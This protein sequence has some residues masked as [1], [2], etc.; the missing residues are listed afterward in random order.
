MKSRI[1]KSIYGLAMASM[2]ALA[3]MLLPTPGL[4]AP[5]PEGAG[6][7][8]SQ[9]YVVGTWRVR[10]TIRDCHT[11]AEIRTFPALVTFGNEGTL[12]ETTAGFPP[13]VRTSGHGF[14]RN[15]GGHNYSA[16]S[17]AFLFSPAGAWIGTQRITQTIEFGDDRDEFTSTATTNFFDPNGNPIPGFPPSSCA[18]AVGRRWNE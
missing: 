8:D 16:V 10:V 14:W 3:V 12:I 15:T 7:S 5:K 2:F 11:G 4:G 18:T 17:E 9:E 1:S 13:A 6:E